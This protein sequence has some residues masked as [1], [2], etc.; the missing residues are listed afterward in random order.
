MALE[1]FFRKNSEQQMRR[2]SDIQDACEKLGRLENVWIGSD[3]AME[4]SIN[5]PPNTTLLHKANIV[6]NKKNLP[7]IKITREV[8]NHLRWS[9]RSFFAQTG[10]ETIIDLDCFTD[11]MF[12]DIN[13]GR[14]VPVPVVLHNYSQRA[15]ELEGDVMRFFWV[16]DRNRLRGEDLLNAIKSGQI[17]IEGEEE[18]DWYLRG[19]GDGDKF[20]T[21]D[22]KSK[23]GLCV[24]VRLTPEKFY[25]PYS[26]EPIK[27]DKNIKTRDQLAS[28]LVKM[29]NGQRSNFEIG[30]TPIIKLGSKIIAVINLGAEDNGQKHIWSPLLDYSDWRVRTE[31]N[32][33]DEIELFLFRK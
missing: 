26:P 16:N 24:V 14:N 13:A 33:L 32:G 2:I 19:Y 27:K 23:E 15:V 3:V 30:E 17:I 10:I 20:K 6:L 28:L 4:K 31:T 21:T 9:V 22:E 11:Q 18:K 5:V 8:M 1:Q 7:P 12:E 25:I 29:P